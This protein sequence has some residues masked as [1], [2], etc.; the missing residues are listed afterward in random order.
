[1]DRLTEITAE[2]DQKW[3]KYQR[4][5]FY[6]QISGVRTPFLIGSRGENGKDNLAVFN[7]VVHIG[8]NPPLLGFIM[9]PTTVERHTYDNIKG[10]EKFSMNLIHEGILEKSHLTSAKYPKEVSEFDAV[11]LAAS[12]DLNL[13]PYVLESYLSLQLKYVEEHLILNGTRLIVG[14]IQRVLINSDVWKERQ[15]VDFELMN[16][17]AVSGLYNYYSLSKL[18]ELARV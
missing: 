13:A 9:R 5:K 7:S 8:A 2:I 3:D 11:G 17:V 16:T 1:M 6:N 12:K 4:I 15:D 18:K 10:T 14:E